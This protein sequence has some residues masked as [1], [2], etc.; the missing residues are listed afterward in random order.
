ML[1]YQLDL[2]LAEAFPLSKLEARKERARKK[3]Y[4][5][6]YKVAK[7]AGEKM[8][9][10]KKML[11]GK[12]AQKYRNHMSFIDSH[13]GMQNALEAYDGS[14]YQFKAMNTRIRERAHVSPVAVPKNWLVIR[15]NGNGRG[16]QLPHDFLPNPVQRPGKNR[17]E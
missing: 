13:N 6:E 2:K 1:D 4:D 10:Y 14:I 16:M 12:S 3:K 5:R 17:C 8:K 7:A 9:S 11:L 15:A